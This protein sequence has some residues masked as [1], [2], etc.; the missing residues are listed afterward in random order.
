MKAS[1]IFALSIVLTLFSCN[2][3]DNYVPISSID[4]ALEDALMLASN[5]Q[6][7]SF[8]MLPESDN[9]IEIPQDINNPIT[10]QKVELGQLLFHETGL[11][12]NPML[13]E[14]ME[15][16]SCASCHH[17]DA[18]F[19]AGKRQGI[20][21]GGMGFGLFGETRDIN[22]LYTPDMLDVQPIKSPTA[23]NSAYQKLM[24]WNGQF[25]ATDQNIGTE[26]QW[27]VGTPK[28]TNNLG[29][30]GVEIQAIAG[31]GVHRMV[32][33]EQIVTDLG[34]KAMF[35]AAFPEIDPSERYTLTTAG[36]AIAAYERTLLANEAPFQQWL[37]GDYTAMSE[38]A[39]QGAVLFFDK[40]QCVSCHSGPSLGA[41]E[42]AAIGVKD[43]EGS[44]IFT[45][46]DEATQKGRGG[47]TLNTEDD[48]KFKVPQLYSIKYNGFYG[49][50]SSFNSIKS[51]IEYKNAGVKENA[52]VP[53]SALD[54]RFLPLGLTEQDINLLAI[55]IE[56]AL[57]DNNLNRYT[58]SSVM[59][60]NCFPNND[61]TSQNDLGCN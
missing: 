19:Q 35:D 17:A 5:N 18:G 44:D 23:L 56:E 53:D 51:I 37:A 47:F 1:K 2:N 40:A 3:D 61:T 24:L 32:V 12:K 34:Y 52:A 55:F 43:L 11:G 36:L 29:F 26:A 6:G 7:K 54:S 49:H 33:D 50:G 41:M 15:T 28:E 60:G 39:K 9:Y 20:G 45:T 59:S 58:P 48:Y 13:D 14:G 57:D 4:L 21:D 8:F 30:E 42:F 38:E 22:P 46:V 16:Y 10:P 25:G 27:T 31:L